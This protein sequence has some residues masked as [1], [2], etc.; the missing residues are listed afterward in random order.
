LVGGCIR[1]E[2]CV[3]RKICVDAT[4]DLDP[5]LH[6]SSLP[7]CIFET[8]EDFWLIFI[9]RMYQGTKLCHA[10]VSG[11]LWPWPCELE[12]EIPFRSVSP[13]RM[14]YIT[15]YTCFW[16]GLLFKVTEVKVCKKLWSCHVSS[17]FGVQCS[18][19]V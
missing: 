19:F 12:T 3:A 11:D 13:K 17:L 9:G 8:N 14:S 5:K 16:F 2:R 18:Y 15:Y 7:L 4:F 6:N 1:G 10:K